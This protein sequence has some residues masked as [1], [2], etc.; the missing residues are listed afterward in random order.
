MLIFSVSVRVYNFYLEYSACI[1]TSFNLVFV[2]VNY[3]NAA[4][5]KLSMKNCDNFNVGCF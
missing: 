3:N 5:K 4:W 2:N 1:N